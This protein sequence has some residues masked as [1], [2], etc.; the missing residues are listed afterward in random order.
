MKKNA[1]EENDAEKFNE[2]K[3]IRNHICNR[4]QYDKINYYKNSFYDK[5]VSS[6]DIWNQANA[7]LNTSKRSFNNSP[8]LIIQDQKSHTAPQDIA[9]AFNNTFIDKVCK[10]RDKVS[11]SPVICPLERLK[12]FLGTKVDSVDEFVLKPINKMQLRN[13]LKRR[14]GNKSSGIDNI[15][16]YSIK[17]AA[18]LME[19]ILLHLVNLSLRNSE[20][21]KSWKLN[22]VLPHYKKGEKMLAENWRPVTNIVFV[23]KLVEAAVYEQI[24]EYFE[25]NSLWHSNHHGFRSNHSTT[26]A[27]SQIYDTWV[28]AAESKKLTAALL[29]DLTAAFDVVDHEI[30]LKKLKVY[31]FSESA[32]KWFKSYLND[33]L[34][35]VQVDSKLSKQ[36]PI[37]DQGVPQ[38]SLLGP[39]LFLI[40]YNDF[41]N[42]REEGMSVLYADDDTDNVSDSDPEIL[43]NK[44]QREA[45]L[46]TTWV[47]DNKLVCSGPK[48]K[49][50]VVGTR[51]LRKSKLIDPNV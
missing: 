47:K 6:S 18:P 7:Y 14:K 25:V 2:Y 3:R 48:T 8:S 50:L 39:I 35:V 27:I 22:K 37:G 32:V 5:N 12:S 38:G 36:L 1:I 24:T 19:D 23:S 20:Y 40:Y 16:G 4:V 21:P 43:Q 45:D 41:P 11:N 30:L 13:L 34:Q 42:S 46:S 33:R 15:D 51:E 26:T 10:I 28:S 29:L 44:I 31:N 17:L 49:L 9:N